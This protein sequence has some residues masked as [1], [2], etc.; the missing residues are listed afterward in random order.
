MLVV[1][2]SVGFYF[3]VGHKSFNCASSIAAVLLKDLFQLLKAEPLQQK[4]RG[5]CRV[6]N[7]AVDILDAE[8]EVREL[9]FLIRPK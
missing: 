4:V 8:T 7:V 2:V 3:E 1:S 9:F 5:M 6:V